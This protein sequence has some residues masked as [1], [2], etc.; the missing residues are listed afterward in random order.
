MTDHTS[1]LT[2]Y[3]TVI[4]STVLFMAR[5]K[6]TRQ[7]KYREP[8]LVNKRRFRSKADAEIAARQWMGILI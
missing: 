8:L 4:G 1:N 3:A 2:H 6:I 5:G 7:K